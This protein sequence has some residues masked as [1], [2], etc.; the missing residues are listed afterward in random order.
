MPRTFY[1]SARLVFKHPRSVREPIAGRG[2]LVSWSSEWGRGKVM[3]YVTCAIEG[4]TA[5]D[6]ALGRGYA[7]VEQLMVG[8]R[9]HTVECAIHRPRTIDRNTL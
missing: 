9:R 6:D 3:L 5:V 4:L 7:I 2:P 8:V 1:I